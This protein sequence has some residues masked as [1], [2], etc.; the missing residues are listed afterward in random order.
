MNGTVFHGHHHLRSTDLMALPI[1]D[2]ACVCVCVCV[3]YVY[4]NLRHT[5][6]HAHSTEDKCLA[7]EFTL[8]EGDKALTERT[9]S[10][11]AYCL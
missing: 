9:V 5:R 6:T 3:V 10:I 7:V 4:T 11:Q 8:A 2:G 1:V